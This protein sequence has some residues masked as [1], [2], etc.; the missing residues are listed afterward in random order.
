MNAGFNWTNT[1]VKRIR[2]PDSLV[3]SPGAENTLYSRQEV[4]WMESGQPKDHYI[5]TGTYSRGPFSALLRGNWFGE[6]ESTE[7]DKL[8]CEA[9]TVLP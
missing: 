9:S 4:I 1:S 3:N 2:I 5:L 8:A 6:V 7:D